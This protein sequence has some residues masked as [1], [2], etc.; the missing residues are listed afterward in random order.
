MKR[1]GRRLIEKLGKSDSYLLAL[2][3]GVFLSPF[4][5]NL[6][7]P[8]FDTSSKVVYLSISFMIVALAIFIIGQKRS[9]DRIEK[10]QT[11]IVRRVGVCRQKVS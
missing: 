4:L 7:S 11:D 2:I 3:V 10:L 5:S 6:T 1:W 9:I 8:L